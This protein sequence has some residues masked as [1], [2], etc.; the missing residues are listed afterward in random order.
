MVT[1]FRKERRLRAGKGREKGR[2]KT[3]WRIC[4]A[5]NMFLFDN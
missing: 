3:V 4:T 1:Q 5:C 2:Y